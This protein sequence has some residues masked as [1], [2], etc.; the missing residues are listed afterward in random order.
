MAFPDLPQVPIE[1][2]LIAKKGLFDSLAGIEISSG[3]YAILIEHGF[4]EAV[5]DLLVRI[6]TEIFS[7]GVVANKE[8][9]LKELD[10]GIT[11]RNVE[12]LTETH[13]LNL[14]QFYGIDQAKTMVR[15]VGDPILKGLDYALLNL[16]VDISQRLIQPNITFNSL[17]TEA[18]RETA[19]LHIKP[20]LNMIKKGEMLLR[21][22][23]RVTPLQLRKLN[24]MERR[25]DIH[26]VPISISG[27]AAL[28]V[29]ILIIQYH[30]RLKS[31]NEI[32]T[33]NNKDLLF[34]TCVIVAIFIV[35]RISTTLPENWFFGLP[36]AR[37]ETSVGYGIPLAAGAMIVCLF[38]GREI[39]LIFSLA[40]CVGASMVLEG[41]IE[42]FLYF[43]LSCTMAA[44]WLQDCRERKVI[45]KAAAKLALL[46]AFL[47]LVIDFYLGITAWST[48][49]FD[50]I[51]AFLGG[52]GAG[53][54][55]TGTAP[56]VEM[57][58]HYTTDITL[59]ELSNLDRPILRRLMLEAPG[60][61]HHSVV[62]GSLV[63]AAAT[64]IGANPILAKVCGY[65]HD[66]GKLKQPLY[67]IENQS[68]GKN[69]HDKL[70]PSMS[71]LILIA[72]VKNG[73]EI[74]REHKLGRSIIDTIQQHHGTSLI[75]FFYEKAKA[76]KGGRC[77]Q[78]QRL[79]ISGA[80]APNA[81]SRAG[82][83]CR[84]G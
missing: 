40:M 58:F 51:V 83:A 69:R 10:K 8:I 47:A 49:P 28:F 60:T 43:I 12:T 25:N 66:I 22:G 38:L 68:N 16:I 74:A 61:Y 84:C 26:H 3:A 29:A 56:V 76:V 34:L 23:E 11:L 54:I 15:V 70:A 79:Q 1:E 78:Y 27:A 42:T 36:W 63:E 73:V 13:I 53:I 59:L 48:L 82:H 7:T 32:G 64:E 6:L 65:Y 57:V 21:E 45:I 44:W 77:G 9:L 50:L 4:S 17:E 80:T 67:F 14:K 20:V 71:A 19:A 37:A 33:Y 52:I 5:S 39:A 46:N 30:V 72:H 41:N 55:T 31:Q 62:V 2:R 81:R 18:R 24:A 75:R 35:V